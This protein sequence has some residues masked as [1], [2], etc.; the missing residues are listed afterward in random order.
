MHIK[1]LFETYK[2]SILM[3]KKKGKYQYI[4]FLHIHFNIIILFKLCKY[5]SFDADFSQYK[6]NF[7][8]YFYILYRSVIFDNLFLLF[9]VT[10]HLKQLF[11][12]YKSR[13]K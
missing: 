2:K 5:W 13:F 8:F 3:T 6:K 10:T 7:T 11:L 12:E 4:I 1:Q 9:I